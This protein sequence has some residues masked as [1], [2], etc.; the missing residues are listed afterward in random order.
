MLATK[1]VQSNS[2]VCMYI[3]KC[4]N[5]MHVFIKRTI[6]KKQYIL[7]LTLRMRTTTKTDSHNLQQVGQTWWWSRS[8]SRAPRSRELYARARAYVVSC[9]CVCVRA[10]TFAQYCESIGEWVCVFC[11]SVWMFVCVSRCLWMRAI[12]TWRFFH[13][14]IEIAAHTN[15]ERYQWI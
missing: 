4:T 13:I 6:R 14:Y 8:L 2:S 3:Y 7:L 12:V 1:H 15:V 11:L 10:R 9:V 5:Y